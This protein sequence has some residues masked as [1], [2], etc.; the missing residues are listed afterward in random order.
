MVL[1]FTMGQSKYIM[2]NVYNGLIW[3]AFP[4]LLVVSNDVF[5]YFSG[6]TMGRKFIHK[7]FIKLSPNKTWEG[8]IGGAILTLIFGWYLASFLAKFSWMTCPTN[9]F[10]MLPDKLDCELH[11][12]F[13][14]A[15][16]IFP[17]QLFDIFPMALVKMV[18]GIV[19][20]CAVRDSVED[21]TIAI[22]SNDP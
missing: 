16:S 10:S 20:I 7:D 2:H 5:A 6:I 3:F 14:E 9:R 11:P 1:C 12:I 21:A 13:H 19:E 4:I 8:F 22:S 17:S 18:P 15:S